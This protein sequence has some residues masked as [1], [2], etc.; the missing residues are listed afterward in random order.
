M[1]DLCA[2]ELLDLSIEFDNKRYATHRGMA[3]QAMCENK[4][5]N[6]DDDKNSY[7]HGF[8]VS[9]VEVPDAIV[10]K[11]LKEKKISRK[12]IKKF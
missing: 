6:A 4:I 10:M 2:Q 8:P 1:P 7:W 11:W 12:D 5:N 9:W 3:F